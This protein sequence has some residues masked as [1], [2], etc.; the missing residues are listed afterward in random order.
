MSGR[1]AKEH[2]AAPAAY[3][4]GASR[5][6][7]GGIKC[8]SDGRRDYFE[9]SAEALIACGIVRSDQL[10]GAHGNAKTR[11]TFDAEGRRVRQG[12]SRSSFTAGRL[13]VNR[14]SA[15]RFRVTVNLSQAEREQRR[16]LEAE[17]HKAAASTRLAVTRSPISRETVDRLKELLVEALRGELTGFA[18]AAMYR[19][20]DWHVAATGEA[21][22]DPIPARGMAMQLSDYLGRVARG[23]E[24]DEDG[25]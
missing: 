20:R 4:S 8:H 9:G 3:E 17:T 12:C 23:E 11:C 7:A 19:S 25:E 13:T 14:I 16:E 24:E 6:S 18:Y 1:R 22:H 21:R 2:S 10:P 5:S 15:T